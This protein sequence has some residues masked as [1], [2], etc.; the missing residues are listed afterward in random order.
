MKNKL[1]QILS[2]L[3]YAIE[4]TNSQGCSV[5]L[6]QKLDSH[7]FGELIE[8]NFAK[9]SKSSTHRYN[10]NPS[11]DKPVAELE[12]F[13]FASDRFVLEDLFGLVL[14][15]I[16]IREPNH[17]TEFVIILSERE[18]MD[19]AEDHDRNIEGVH[20]AWDY[21]QSTFA[22]LYEKSKELEP[23]RIYA[24]EEGKL[25]VHFLLNEVYS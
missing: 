19:D 13:N 10:V 12:H 22:G 2:G 20:W 4:V 24:V 14:E 15:H 9:Y 25:H 7:R 8:Y 21:I 11:V 17:L 3:K 1:K 6:N 5:K 18:L 16:D 23:Q